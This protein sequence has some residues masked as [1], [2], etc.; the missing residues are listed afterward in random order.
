[1]LACQQ[2]SKTIGKLNFSTDAGFG[3]TEALKDCGGDDVAGG[4]R[5]ATWGL[6]LRGFFNQRID[7]PQAGAE[8]LPADDPV[9]ADFFFGDFFQADD[10]GAELLIGLDELLRG[11]IIAAENRIAELAEKRMI[12]NFFA[13]LENRVAEAALFG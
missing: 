11:K 6:I 4:D 12:A 5:Q 13:S 10:G 8:V 1:R 2:K 9:A 7:F 3:F